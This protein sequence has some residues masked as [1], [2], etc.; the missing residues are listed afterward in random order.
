[1][2]KL[3]LPKTTTLNLYQANR[4]FRQTVLEREILYLYISQKSDML[5][6]CQTIIS[7]YHLGHVKTNL[8]SLF[9]LNSFTPS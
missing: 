2:M 5:F 9:V 4:A 6:F 8:Y 3:S 7:N 1:M